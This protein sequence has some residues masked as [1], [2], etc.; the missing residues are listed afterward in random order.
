MTLALGIAKPEP[1]MRPRLYKI[2]HSSRTPVLAAKQ[3]TATIPIVMGAIGDPP[4]ALGVLINA[5]IRD[6]HG[7]GRPVSLGVETTGLPASAATG[8]PG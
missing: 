3:A 7:A 8:N 5:Q 6:V 4:S 2:A 1:I